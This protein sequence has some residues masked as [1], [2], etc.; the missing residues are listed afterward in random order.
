MSDTSHNITSSKYKE[1]LEQKHSSVKTKNIVMTKETENRS[2]YIGLLTWNT[3]IPGI[4]EWLK[5]SGESQNNLQ[6]QHYKFQ[7]QKGFRT[8]TYKM[9]NESENRPIKEAYR[10]TLN[11]RNRF[12]RSLVKAKII[13]I[14]YDKDYTIQ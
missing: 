1:Y 7:K 11:P 9:M 4:C 10:E 14:E 5:E 12:Q 13:V 3:Q 2:V 8:K 6:L